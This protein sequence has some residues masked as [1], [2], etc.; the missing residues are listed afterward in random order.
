MAGNFVTDKEAAIL[1]ERIQ[2]LAQCDAE[3]LR[4]LYRNKLKEPVE[5]ASK[6]ASLGLIEIARRASLPLSCEVI[7]IA[8]IIIYL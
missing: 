6:G 1:S 2:S 7:K 3:E 5:E 4:Q 8:V